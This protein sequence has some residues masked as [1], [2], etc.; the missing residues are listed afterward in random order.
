MDRRYRH[1]RRTHRAILHTFQFIF[2]RPTTGPRYARPK[3]TAEQSRHQRDAPAEYLGSMSP[4]PVLA[5]YYQEQARRG[6]L[7][8]PN[9][10]EGYKQR[11][12]YTGSRC[13]PEEEAEALAMIGDNDLRSRQW[14]PPPEL[15]AAGFEA[16]QDY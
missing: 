5:H 15:E 12:R 7:A 11:L 14:P 13:T 8:E 16:A 4:N 10:N 3:L 2:R 9:I 6:L 1:I